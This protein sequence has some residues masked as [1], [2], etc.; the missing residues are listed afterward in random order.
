MGRLE[1]KIAII[2]GGNSGIGR[3]TAKLF[4]R[5]GASV[6]IVSRRA[7][8]NQE[9]V[10][11]ITAE[12]GNIIAIQADVSKMEDCRRVVDETIKKFGRIDILVNNAGIAD[13]HI[14]INLCTEEW[15]EKVCKIDQFS[16]FYM[17]KYTLE[18]MEKCG[19]GSI[20]NVSSIGSQG[21]AG[22]AYSA[23]KAAVN[24][25]TKNIAL[26]YS[27]TDIRCNAVAP[28]PTPTELNSPEQFKLFNHEFAEACARHIDLTVPEAQAEDQAEAILFFASDASKAITGQILYVDHGTSLY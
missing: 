20:V 16:V 27:H 14:P 11:E 18:Y 21:I 23:A 17:T 24:S 15:Y 5:E 7:E 22:I 12:G 13:R 25:M 8:K 1:G 26:Q 28:G 10:D 19:K 4:C 6:V 9:T 3:A 2:T